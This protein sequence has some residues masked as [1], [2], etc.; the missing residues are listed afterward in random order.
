MENNYSFDITYVAAQDIFDVEEYINNTLSNTDASIALAKEIKSK[1]EKVC[2][3]PMANHDCR[4][5]GIEDE[6]YRYV[7]IK[8][9]N[10]FYY[11]DKSDKKVTFIRFLYSSRDIKSNAIYKGNSDNN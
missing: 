7:K 9:Y 1:I 8:R 2:K 10:F 5:Y 11:V 3:L 4:Y 6:C